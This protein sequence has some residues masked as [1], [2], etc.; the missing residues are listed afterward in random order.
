MT[1]LIKELQNLTEKRPL[2]EMA[3]VGPKSMG[4]GFT[5]VIYSN[6]RAPAHVH[7][8]DLDGKDLGRFLLP[9]EAPQDYTRVIE[10]GDDSLHSTIKK[11]IV[12]WANKEQKKMNVT[13]WVSAHIVWNSFH[14]E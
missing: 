10:Y 11:K 1:K 13:N 7:V 8:I 6:D 5:L 4:L 3:T 12:E 14:S 9:E 2:V